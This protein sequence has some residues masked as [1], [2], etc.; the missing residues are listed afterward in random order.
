MVW[1]CFINSE[2]LGTCKSFLICEAS[3]VEGCSCR[4]WN[5][6]FHLGEWIDLWPWFPILP[7][8]AVFA[9]YLL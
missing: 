6:G 4:G 3:G 2:G 9:Q 8:K 5:Q 1:M 7:R